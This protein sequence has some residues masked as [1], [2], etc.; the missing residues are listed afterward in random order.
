MHFTANW[1]TEGLQNNRTQRNAPWS[2]LMASNLPFCRLPKPAELSTTDGLEADKDA[3][4]AKLRKLSDDIQ[5]IL[6]PFPLV[7]FHLKT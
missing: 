7:K 6:V 5:P 4:D 3:I 1:L 2:T